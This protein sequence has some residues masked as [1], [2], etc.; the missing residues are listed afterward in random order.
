MKRLWIG[1]GLAVGMIAIA[2]RLGVPVLLE[3][4]KPRIE[5]DLGEALGLEVRI[6]DLPRIEFF[7]ELEIEAGEVRVANLPG[8]ASPHL[9]E[10]AR[11]ELE[12]RLLPLLR[13]NIVIDTFELYDAVLRVEPDEAGAWSLRADPS[14]LDEAEGD[15]PDD[16]VRL[17]LHSLEIHD[18]DVFVER[19]AE[20]GTEPLRIHDLVIHE[21][22]RRGPLSLVGR[23]SV[24]GLGTIDVDAR[25]GSFA[26]LVDP[27]GP[28]P[29]EL[30]ARIFEGSLEAT[31]HFGAPGTLR[32]AELRLVA[33][34]ADLARV[35]RRFDVE[36]PRLGPASVSALLVKRDGPIGLESLSVQ[37]RGEG[38]V[39]L[40]IEGS[41][42]NLLDAEG[43]DLDLDLALADADLLQAWTSLPIPNTPVQAELELDDDDGSL[44]IEGSV[45]FERP[46]VVGV[47]F[48]GGLD[49][50]RRLRELDLQVVLKSK[51][52]ELLS[53]SLAPEFDWELPDLGPLEARGRLVI[54]DGALR[55]EGFDAALGD[56]EGAWARARGSVADLGTL[57][58]VEIEARVGAASARRLAAH[59][60]RTIPELGRLEAAFFVRDS[61]GSLGIEAA[62]LTLERP[63]ELAFEASGVFDDL[64]DL[65]E[66]DLD[67]SLYARDLGVLAA[68]AEVE[69]ES[70]GEVRFEGELHGTVSSLESR[71]RMRI[72]ET[73]F[74]GEIDVSRP[75]EDG[76]PRLAVQLHSPRLHLPDLLGAF[77]SPA[78]AIEAGSGRSEVSGD[79]WEGDAILPF[80]AL[81]RLDAEVRI[82]ADLVTGYE[83]LNA[84]HVRLAADLEDGRLVVHDFGA[85]Y[86]NGSVMGRL[87]IDAR[88]AEPRT[89]LE[90]ETFNVDLTT[91]MSQIQEDT[92]YAGR[93]DLSIALDAEGDSAPEL[94]SSLSGVFGGMLRD[95][96][97]V[98]R[99]S[100]AFTFD[101][102]RISMPSFRPQEQEA[103]PVRC[104][105]ALLPIEDGV[106]TVDTLY[107]AAPRLT[108]TGEG[109]IDLGRDE[110][111]LRLTPRVQDPGVVSVAATVDV[112]GP[113]ESPEIRL[114]RRS[115]FRSAL[116]AVVENLR[117]PERAVRSALGEV[118]GFE[119]RA[120]ITEIEDPC[121]E[122]ANRRIR[123]MQDRE[124]DSADLEEI[125]EATP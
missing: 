121:G 69:L 22:R 21:T 7:P 2:V 106:A 43:V 17:V 76:R 11:L 32:A 89:A 124:G 63:G 51:T 91:L 99:Y 1:L 64:R 58:G 123:Q 108:I 77:R 59:F 9:L 111:D 73:H 80:D 40:R 27:P 16:P 70:T 115:I 61:D 4:L 104:L 62:T 117:R 6:G 107:L 12:L 79:G 15:E 35:A 20:E 118:F 109:T 36:L 94:R 113:I 60:D 88:P 46:G 90:I 8:R 55:L 30:E 3:G 98:N 68:L 5:Q 82:G 71:G 116:G 101:V 39:D 92:P 42:A 37:T 38:P 125:V 110:F 14:E 112:S 57:T 65:E 114:L 105:L 102:L 26:E 45:E 25:T 66:I 34:I 96:A 18:L 13:R 100:R 74:E 120:A 52:L 95:G 85:E 81:H 48:E 10:I 122:V 87:E 56:A 23:A 50:L 78:P 86:E 53:R 24:A 33:E 44:G 83:L 84:Q 93:L 103:A 119:N 75:D 41:V 29:L 47:G 28:I 72:G 49:D 67:A 31:G 97:I 54:D 19:S